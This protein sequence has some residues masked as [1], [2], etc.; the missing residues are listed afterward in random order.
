[1]VLLRILL[2][3]PIDFAYET[4]TLFG[5]LFQKHSAIHQLLTSKSYNLCLKQIWANSVS[6]AATQEISF[7]LFS[8]SYLD[9]SVR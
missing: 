5:Y 9:V 4:I 7:D 6:L 8:F 3:K 2:K 1:M